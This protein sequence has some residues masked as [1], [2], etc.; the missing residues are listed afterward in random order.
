MPE[1]SAPSDLDRR[2]MMKL[3]GTVGAA[4]LAGCTDLAP[5]GG[6]GGGGPELVATLGANVKNTDPTR[7]NDTTSQKATDLIY[8]GVT[9]VD[10]DGKPQPSLATSVEQ[11]GDTEFTINLREGV[12]F[13]NG[14]ELTAEDV[15]SSYERY[16]GS[17]RQS[18]VYDWYD[19]SSVAGDYTLKLTLSRKYAPIRYALAE[20]PIVPASYAT[21]TVTQTQ[22]GT[23]TPVTRSKL[24]EKPVGTGP[25]KFDSRESGSY[26]RLV[27]N[28][29]YWFEGDDSL[30]AQPPVGT[31]T[32]RIV[33]GQSQRA[34]A[35]ESGSVDMINEPPAEKVKDYENNDAY[36]YTSRTAGGFDMFVYPMH[37]AADTPFQNR[38]VRQG[39]T[40]LIPRENIVETVYDGIGQ[41]AYAPI[42]PLSRQYTEDG[43]EVRFASESF[44]EEMKKKYS[45]YDPAAAK[46][47]LAQGFEEA[48][49]DKPFKT[50]II[51][52]SDNPQRVDWNT[53]IKEE[54]N[55][56]EFF[57]VSLQTLEFSTYVSK[58]LGKNSHKQNLIYAVG[59]SAGWGP[60]AYVHNLFHPD[61]FTPAC[62][63][64]NHY[65]VS[66][67]TQ[68]IEN[69]LAEYDTKKRQQ[70]YE[71]LQR[72]IVQDAP[73]AF[74]RFGRRHVVYN[75]NKVDGF[76][77]YPIDGH[78][79]SAVFEE[80]AGKYTQ[81]K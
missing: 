17:P 52:N 51:T 40:R 35:L 48:G 58:L 25:F 43:E 41:P 39:A 19:S 74:I 1:D 81:L 2:T 3:A 42:S 21:E 62:C 65:D 36:T 72:K 23:A 11:N 14:D 79:Y 57:D 55:K 75:A 59:W 32:F 63:N 28:E 68:G 27:R 6:G 5:G 80:A 33:K 56:T 34:S 8:E 37:P 26:F 4:G 7:Q 67:V 18:D 69:G 45:G 44:Q 53:I 78:L 77:A 70:I 47:L 30:P 60:D 66:A 31:L 20:V 15:K 10:F 16:D 61:Q 64:I 50:T 29:D 71:N 46:D 54:M 76:E 73:M 49:F 38:K 13:H 9:F 12:T 22:E 24:S